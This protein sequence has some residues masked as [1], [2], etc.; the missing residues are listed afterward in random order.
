MDYVSPLPVEHF[1][2]SRLLAVIIGLIALCFILAAVF[3]YIQRGQKVQLP[4]NALS[5]EAKAQY[6][7]EMQAAVESQPALAPANESALIKQM[8]AII[9]SQPVPTPEEKASMIEAMST[10]L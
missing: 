3:I 7:N 8:Q 5:A 10:K 6:I 9:Q 2:K 4:S 1:G